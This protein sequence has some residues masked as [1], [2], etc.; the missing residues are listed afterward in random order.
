VPSVSSAAGT[1]R[2]ETLDRVALTFDDGPSEWTEPILDILAANDAH[3]TFFVIGS[4]ARQRADLVRRMVA[5]G[6][7]LGNH[8]WSH[9]ALASD[10]DDERV[11]EELERTNVA[12]AEIVGMAPH[13]FRAPHYNVDDR[14]ESIAASLGLTHTRGDVAPPDW[15]P[16]AISAVTATFVLQQV[17]PGAMINLH[18]GVPPSEAGAGHSRQPTVDAVATIVPRLRERGYECVTASQLLDG[19]RS[20]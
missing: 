5:A 3:A 17:E 20:L 7:E 19:K 15:H 12:I 10:C 16:G 18:D 11:R 14:V 4:L 1:A 8:S 13:R 9:P 6:H 2:S